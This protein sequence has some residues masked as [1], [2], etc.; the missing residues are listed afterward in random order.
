MTS[1]RTV[2]WVPLYLYI[3]PCTPPLAAPQLLLEGFAPPAVNRTRRT[4]GTQHLERGLPIGNQSFNQILSKLINQLICR[5][6]R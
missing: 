2:E 6:I 3:A 1:N 5:Y 4:P